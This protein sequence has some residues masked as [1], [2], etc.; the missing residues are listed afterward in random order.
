MIKNM[1][2]KLWFLSRRPSLYHLEHG[3][4]IQPNTGAK[5]AS[6]EFERAS[7]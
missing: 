4:I 7:H 1:N 3:S 2:K 6:L 5:A